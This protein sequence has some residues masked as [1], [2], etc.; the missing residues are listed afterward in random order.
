MRRLGF[1]VACFG[2]LLSASGCKHDRAQ[3][4]AASYSSITKPTPFV[5]A[6]LS[7]TGI[8]AIPVEE[9]YEE[10]SRITIAPGNLSVELAQ[11]EKELGH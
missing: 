6:P 3:A 10:R 4:V 1:V 8:A 5:A 2:L 11:I 7:A 9:E